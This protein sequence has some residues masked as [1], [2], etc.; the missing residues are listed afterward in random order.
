MKNVTVNH[1]RRWESAKRE[2]KRDGQREKANAHLH[3]TLC[4]FN[5][6]SH[7]ISRC[8]QNVATFIYTH[9]FDR[10]LFRVARFNTQQRDRTRKRKK[11]ISI[12]F[13]IYGTWSSVKWTLVRA[14]GVSIYSHQSLHFGFYGVHLYTCITITINTLTKNSSSS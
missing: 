2:R 6:I 5:Y 12:F 9:L 11:N 10:R 1:C 13:I 4:K 7:M 14:F 8:S 3:W